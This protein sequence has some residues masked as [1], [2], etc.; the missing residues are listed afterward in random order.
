MR[1]KTRVPTTVRNL[2]AMGLRHR[3]SLAKSLGIAKW[4]EKNLH[5]FPLWLALPTLL[6]VT[7]SI[8]CICDNA[9]IRL[10]V[11]LVAPVTE[12]KLLHWSEV[13]TD[14]HQK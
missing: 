8:Y 12:Y 1:E 13:I 7:Y 9:E 5:I 11:L 4:T 14:T 3:G 2:S 10:H 6:M